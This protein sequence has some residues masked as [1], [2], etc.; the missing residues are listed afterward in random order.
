MRYFAISC[1]VNDANACKASRCV[2]AMAEKADRPRNRREVK[3]L[4]WQEL[5]NLHSKP[6]KNK[7]A[8]ISVKAK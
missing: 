3:A 2:Y 5:E 1:A 6:T 7:I 8:T 4:F